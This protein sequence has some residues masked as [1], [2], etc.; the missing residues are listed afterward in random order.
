MASSLSCLL[1]L[2]TVAA[3][4]WAVPAPSRTQ[5]PPGFPASREEFYSMVRP[6]PRAVVGLRVPQGPIKAA[7]FG[8]A[9]SLDCTYDYDEGTYPVP[10]LYW[11]RVANTD[12]GPMTQRLR[13]GMRYRVYSLTETDV[14]NRKTLTL[15]F[16]DADPNDVGP[17]TCNVEGFTGSAF[18]LLLVKG[19][20]PPLVY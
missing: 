10:K 2:F 6:N 20:P 1:I 5:L 8:E 4:A 9:V 11:S 17:Y 13:E 16:E 14:D 7:T 18:V 19:G 12:E 3:L 15:S